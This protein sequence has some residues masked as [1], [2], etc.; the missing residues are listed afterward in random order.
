MDVEEKPKLTGYIRMRWKATTGSL[1]FYAD[2][3]GPSC[4][5]KKCAETEALR[6][7]VESVFDL[8]SVIPEEPF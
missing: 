3:G 2:K 8:A 6:A 1:V 4:G 7:M 5:V